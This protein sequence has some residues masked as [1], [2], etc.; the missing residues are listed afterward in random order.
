[1]QYGCTVNLKSSRTRC[2]LLSCI[3]FLKC[4]E[5]LFAFSNTADSSAGIFVKQ[6]PVAPNLHSLMS[7]ARLEPAHVCG[8]HV[9]L[10][11]A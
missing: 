3:A 5:S 9:F 4:P 8:T 6:C 1:M 2:S 10:P 7:V 11:C